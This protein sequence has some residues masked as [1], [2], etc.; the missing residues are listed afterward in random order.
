MVFLVH[1]SITNG[2]NWMGRRVLTQFPVVSPEINDQQGKGVLHSEEIGQTP[3]QPTD[4][5]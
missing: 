1:A 5:S 2:E 3:S 4:Q